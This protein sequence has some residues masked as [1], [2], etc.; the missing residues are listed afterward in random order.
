MHIE[1]HASSVCFRSLVMLI[2]EKYLYCIDFNLSDHYVN[3]F[4]LRENNLF[5]NV[6]Y[7]YGEARKKYM[8]SSHTT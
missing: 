2:R 7:Y 4:I 8:P 5:A 6:L 3:I 1:I